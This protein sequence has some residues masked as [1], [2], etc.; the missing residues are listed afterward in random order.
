[1]YVLLQYSVLTHLFSKVE[2]SACVTAC[3]AN[4]W[5]TET[6]LLSLKCKTKIKLG[7]IAMMNNWDNEKQMVSL[8]QKIPTATLQS[9]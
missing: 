8:V 3:E 2:F 7:G 6:G 5:I 9:F 4:I 1:M